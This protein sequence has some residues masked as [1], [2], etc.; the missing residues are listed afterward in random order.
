MRIAGSL[1]APREQLM[2]V[3]ADMAALVSVAGRGRD[4]RRRVQRRYMTAI[5]AAYKRPAREAF[6][7]LTSQ[8]DWDDEDVERLIERH[9]SGEHPSGVAG[10]KAAENEVRRLMHTWWRPPK[11]WQGWRP[12]MVH[13][14]VRATRSTRCRTIT[15]TASTTKT[16]SGGD[17]GGGGDGGPQP[18]HDPPRPRHRGRDW[19]TRLGRRDHLAAAL[20]ARVRALWGRRARVYT[21]RRMFA[22]AYT[23][24]L[25]TGG[26]R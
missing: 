12:R 2:E 17:S 8:D 24:H 25:V 20:V 1:P 23:P 11:G 13:R 7:E 9:N 26:A 3:M 22:R 16:A 14:S 18:D 21:R 10:V 19:A 15:R 4:E 5:L 6:D